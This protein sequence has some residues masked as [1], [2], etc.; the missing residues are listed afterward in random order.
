MISCDL[1]RPVQNTKPHLIPKIHPIIRAESSPEAKVRKQI[2]QIN[3]NRGFAYIFR[4]FF[5][6]LVAG[7]DSGCIFWGACWGSEGL[8]I[9]HG[10]QEIVMIGLK[11]TVRRSSSEAARKLLGK[12][13]KILGSPGSY[14]RAL[15]KSGFLSATC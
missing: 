5:P 11:S 13:G 2:R 1:P 15:G 9:L 14:Q 10:A 7:E 6:Y 3:E 4:I 12:C 8:C